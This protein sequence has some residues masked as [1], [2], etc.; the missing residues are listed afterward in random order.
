MQNKDKVLITG[1]NSFIGKHLLKIYPDAEIV[2]RDQGWYVGPDLIFHLAAAGSK[3]G[4]Y[5]E[6]EIFSTNVGGT[7]NLLQ[8]TRDIPY[9]AFI[10]FS[11]SSVYGIKDHP[12][13]E[14]DN[15][16]PNFLY[17]S[18]KA[19]AEMLCRNEAIEHNKPVVNVRPFSVYGPGMQ[20]NKL[21]PVLFDRIKRNEQVELVVGNHDFIYIDDFLAGLDT[22]VNNARTLAGH[23]LNIGSGEQWSNYD[24]ACLVSQIVGKGIQN[25]VEVDRLHDHGH[26]TQLDSPMWQADISKLKTLGWSPKV[27]LREGLTRFYES[28]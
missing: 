8:T 21:I 13:R 25:I 27:S 9:K 4:N 16:E 6:K 17:A 14:D 26:Q 12:M 23:A 24:L 20:D 18:T 3:R 2:G 22:V 28:T 1:Y 15:L 7:W 5:T 10:N 11:S 19:A